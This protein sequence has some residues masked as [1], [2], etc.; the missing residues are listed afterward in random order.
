MYE[1]ILSDK[2][3]K[4][5]EKLPLIIKKRIAA[6]IERI[7]IRPFSFV[8]KIMGSNYYRARVGEYR[9]ILNIQKYKLIIHIIELGHRKNIY[10]NN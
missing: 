9:I 5:L 2:A 8:K 7:K 6:V 1:I 3:E 10:K 4:Q